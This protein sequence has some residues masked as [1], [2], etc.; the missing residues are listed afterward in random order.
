VLF[1]HRIS[2]LSLFYNFTKG[3]NN[4]SDDVEILENKVGLDSLSNTI[5]QENG[6]K[7]KYGMS[8]SDYKSKIF[9]ENNVE[10]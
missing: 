6:F 5:C 1:V 2:Y 10:Y 4:Y 9:E 7:A 8:P 3:Y